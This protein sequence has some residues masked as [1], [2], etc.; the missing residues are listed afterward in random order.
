MCD[1]GFLDLGDFSEKTLNLVT[2]ILEFS[3]ILIKIGSEYSGWPKSDMPTSDTF[4]KN[5]RNIPCKMFLKLRNV[6]FWSKKSPKNIRP[7]S[8]TFLWI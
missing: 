8:D 6:D 5:S 7:K 1:Y 3:E 2:Q 4:S